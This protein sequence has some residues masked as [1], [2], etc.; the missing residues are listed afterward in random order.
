MSFFNIR[1][2]LRTTLGV[3][4]IVLFISLCLRWFSSPSAIESWY[5]R[6]VFTWFRPLW[7][8][9]IGWSPLPLFYGFW[10]LIIFLFI[11]L[12][13]GIRKRSGF[14]KRGIYTLQRL[15]IF[16]SWLII[17]FLWFWGYNYGRIPVEKQ[18]DFSTYEMPLPELINSVREG[19]K[20]VTAARFDIKGA[21]SSAVNIELSGKEWTTQIR[22]LLIQALVADGYPVPGRPNGRMLAP[23]G[24]ILRFSASGVYWPWAAEGNVDA[25]N[26]SLLKAPILAHE[27]AHAYGFGEEGT[28]SFWSWRAGTYAKDPQLKYAFLLHYWRELARKWLSVDREG[29]TKFYRE[30]LAPGIRE[31]IRAIIKN[32]RLY[33]DIMPELRDIAY[34]AYLK[35]QG[36]QGGLLSY[37]R[38]VKLVEG[39]KR[40]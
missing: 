23:K 30:E 16:C 3:T 36:M 14:K 17:T 11:K 8:Y 9:T 38:V 18:L 28:C 25:G 40:K 12:I 2:A 1:N 34:D 21:D 4:T 37:R 10:L 5:S 19:A 22:P 26:H 32:Q 27:L 24:I 33:P 13:L 35:A 7:D 29:Y 31:D 39:Y 6:G 20:T 15:Y